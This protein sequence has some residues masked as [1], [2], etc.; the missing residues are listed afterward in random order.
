MPL[1][2]ELKGR[3]IAVK[4][5]IA[6]AGIPCTNGTL[7][8]SW[9]PQID[10]T[11]ITRLLDASGLILG[12]AA[13]EN[14]CLESISD[15]SVTGMVHNPYA[16]GYSCGGS[17]SGSGR[18]VASGQVDMSLGCDQ[19]GSIRIPASS[20]GLVGLKPTW[21]LL[22]YT[23]IISLE[24]TIDHVG[25]MTKTV[26]DSALLMDVL[27]G[28]DGID[29]RQPYSL[30]P[31][32]IKFVQGVDEFLAHSSPLAGIKIGALKEGFECEVQD[33]HVTRLVMSAVEGLKAL[34]AEVEELSIPSHTQAAKL[35]MTNLQ[36]AG[37]RQG[38]LSDATGRKQLCLTDRV[39]ATGRQ[40]S[41]KAFD[42]FSAASQNLYLQALYLD[43]QYGPVL[44][45]KSQNL[46]RKLNVRFPFRLSF[47]HP[48]FAHDFCQVIECQRKLI[49][50]SRTNTTTLSRH[51]TSSS[52]PR[53]PR[54][55]APSPRKQLLWAR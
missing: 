48:H 15:S 47:P 20:C 49:M 6:L 26:R 42:S 4:D 34:G 17:S 36:I 13:C 22:P 38:L 32:S 19:G 10:A 21:G 54:S 14:A 23:G 29:D 27:A 7:A 35:W 11:V 30:T 28:C 39:E 37:M 44:H 25:P 46:L 33:P 50:A 43:A 40:L 53:S 31:G 2:S 41:Q 8:L 55:R 12:K 3:T 52:C 18:L 24:V 16:D 1:S 9:T 45:A 51:L 5:N